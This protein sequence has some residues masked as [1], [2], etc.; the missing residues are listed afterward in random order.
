MAPVPFAVSA[1]T[2]SLVLPT[3]HNTIGAAFLGV[4]GAAF[5]FGIT[6]LQIYYYYHSYP[7]DIRLHKIS[8][9]VLG[10]LDAFHFA[11]TIHS[12]YTYVVVGFGN[13]FGLMKVLW[14]IQ[15]Q[16]A[17]NVVI[18]FIVHCLYAKRVWTLNGYHGG[19]LGYITIL[20]VAGA[21]GIGIALAYKVFTIQFYSELHKIDWAITAGLSTSSAIDLFIAIAMCYYLRKSLGTGPL[22]NSKISVVIQYALNTGLMTSACSLAALFCYVLL[23]NTFVFLG[24][25]F[26][27]TKLYVASFVGMLNAR[28][29]T[30]SDSATATYQDS[31]TSIPTFK[32]RRHTSS[33]WS[34][35]PLPPLPSVVHFDTTRHTFSPSEDTKVASMSYAI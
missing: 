21:G 25:E 16:V 22:L 18:I 23:P 12:V 27:L 14:S 33:F 1:A 13:K 17:V 15:L 34:P 6:T 32:K 3:L 28:E 8:V 11:L 29:K 9:G 2:S 31:M 35:P 24:L 5:L 30:R 7:N 26:L 4:V 19:V 10:I 20:V